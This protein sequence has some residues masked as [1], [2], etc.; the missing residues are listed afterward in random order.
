MKD[1]TASSSDIDILNLC[2]EI[3]RRIELGEI[4]YVHCWG[5]HG[6]AGIVCSV[7]LAM[8]YKLR[9]DVAMK[10][11]QA[12]HDCRVEPL[13]V[14]SPQTIAQH[15]QV[16]RIIGSKELQQYWENKNTDVY[17][18]TSRVQTSTGYLTAR[19]QSPSTANN[20]IANVPT[21]PLGKS[22]RR[23]TSISRVERVYN[24]FLS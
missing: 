4:V 12:F 13:G 2:I 24:N 10:Y 3:I 9:A 11:I 16:G 5:G 15:V 22:K 18:C 6:R 20:I 19:P 8:I 21:K 7:T 1:L 23:G 14:T 17:I